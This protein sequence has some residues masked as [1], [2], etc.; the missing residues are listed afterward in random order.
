MMRYLGSDSSRFYATML[1]YQV[2]SYLGHGGMIWQ[3]MLFF[4]HETFSTT[5]HFTDYGDDDQ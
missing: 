1:H 3:D 2:K 4:S 5:R